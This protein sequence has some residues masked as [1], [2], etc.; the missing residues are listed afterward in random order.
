MKGTEFVGHGN[1]RFT[2]PNHP[3]NQMNSDKNEKADEPSWSNLATY[4]HLFF[5]V[6]STRALSNAQ[7]VSVLETLVDSIAGIDRQLEQFNDFAVLIELNAD[8]ISHFDVL[9]HIGR[10]SLKQRGMPLRHLKRK[11]ASFR[12]D[13]DDGA[14]QQAGAGRKLPGDQTQ[15]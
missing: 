4:A 3:K 14:A 7:G 2:I 12:I 1:N 10:S 8:P 6:Y 9:Q 5:T 11:F 13:C 15:Q